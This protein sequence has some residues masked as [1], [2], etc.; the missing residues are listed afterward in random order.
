VSR[1][2]EVGARLLAVVLRP[3]PP[4]RSTNAGWRSS[5]SLTMADELSACCARRGRSG[6]TC[7]WPLVW[8][9]GCSGTRARFGSPFPSRNEFGAVLEVHCIVV[10]PFPAPDKAVPLEYLDDLDR[11][12][13]AIRDR[14]ARLAA[15]PAPVM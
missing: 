5:A 11:D 15:G 3:P 6:A 13:V 2:V 1:L 14:G 8:V 7:R 4:P 9:S 12:R 10:I